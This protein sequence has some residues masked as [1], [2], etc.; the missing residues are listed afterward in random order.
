MKN[1]LLLILLSIS[2]CLSGCDFEKSK[3]SW[4]TAKVIKTEYVY[5]DIDQSMIYHRI[6]YTL[7]EYDGGHEIFQANLSPLETVKAEYGQMNIRMRT[8]SDNKRK[9]FM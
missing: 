5:R 3:S 4:V 1:I 8:Y 2:L 6:F 7:P 9:V